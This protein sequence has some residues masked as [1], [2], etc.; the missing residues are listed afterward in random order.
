MASAIFLPVYSN[1]SH[2]SLLEAH[3]VDFGSELSDTLFI[4]TINDC[5]MIKIRH[6][7]CEVDKV[8]FSTLGYNCLGQ[9]YLLQAFGDLALIICAYFK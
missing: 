5:K 1:V 7:G 9:C 2:L 6:T 3:E 8:F 4:P